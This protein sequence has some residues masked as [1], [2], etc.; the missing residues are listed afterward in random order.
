[1]T[2]D[3]IKALIKTLRE[4]GVTHY[5]SA[6]LE[7]NLGPEPVVNAPEEKEIKSKLEHLSSLLRLSDLDL[8]DQLFPT[9]DEAKE[10][11]IS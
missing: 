2:I 6:D 10:Q 5:K 1:M 8:V 4:C 11:D 3:E 7:L 9:L